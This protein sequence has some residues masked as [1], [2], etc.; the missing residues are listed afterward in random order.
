MSV[1]G[2]L[3]LAFAG[4]TGRPG[5]ELDLLPGGPRIDSENAT[6]ALADRR[7]R[8]SVVRLSP[9]VHGPLDHHGF[10]PALIAIARATGVAG[11]LGDGANRW[12]AV[13]TADAARLCRLALENAPAGSRLHAV[14]DEGVAFREI[15]EAIGRKLGVPVQAVA[16]ADAGEHFTYLAQIVGLDNP[17]SN[18]HTRDL[19]GW[20]PIL[21]GLIEDLNQDHYFGGAAA[22]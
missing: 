1:G 9:L 8:S 14:A 12:P 13:Q 7:V 3:M 16:A 19:L 5:T 20:Q 21:P 11:Y 15:A 17:T 4:I 18:A 6:I 2:T 22:S 10:T